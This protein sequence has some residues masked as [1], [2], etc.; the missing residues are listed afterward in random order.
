MGSNWVTVLQ[1]KLDQLRNV[2]VSAAVCGSRGQGKSTLI[3]TLRGLRPTDKGAAP[4]GVL[5]TTLEPKSYPFP[6]NENI[7]LW[8]LPGV[9][10]P[11]FP[12]ETYAERVGLD[13]YDFLL[14]L[15]HTAFTEEDV[16]LASRLALMKKPYFFIRTKI[17]EDIKNQLED[18]GH[19]AD[20]TV[21]SIRH[22]AT[23]F[24]NDKLPTGTDIPIKVFV[25][26]AKKKSNHDFP[27]LETQ[28]VDVL[29]NV[30]RNALIL[31]LRSYSTA[32]LAAKAAALKEE[33]IYIAGLSA[34]VAAFPIV[35]FSIAADVSLLT[36]FVARSHSKFGLNRH[37]IFRH[38]GIMPNEKIA[39][40]LRPAGNIITW[41][42]ISAALV[43][44]VV[45]SSLALTEEISRFVPVAG[46]VI[47]A[48]IS[49]G[50][51]KWVLE[52]LVSELHVIAT[53]LASEIIRV[54]EQE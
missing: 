49:Y 51:T 23:K 33:I 31:E 50:T 53:T 6:E 4:V 19:S 7:T 29:P 34:A 43:K 39:A 13:K 36:T 42:E 10:T 28:I 9:G 24:V 32:M 35:G 16:W 3:N 8:D 47:A 45:Y 40:I 1:I 18:Y 22:A 14:I 2:P 25:L 21:T 52:K 5:E 27:E 11:L 54:Q 44:G 30:K 20:R 48:G 46:S 17:D 12:R 38:Y 15:S 37:Q 41:T 26:N